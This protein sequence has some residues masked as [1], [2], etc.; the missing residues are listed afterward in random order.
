MNAV[1]K[2]RVLTRAGVTIDPNIKNEELEEN[3]M[4]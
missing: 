4:P 3:K 1:G 2:E